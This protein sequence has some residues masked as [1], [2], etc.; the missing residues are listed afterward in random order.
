[1]LQ[2]FQISQGKT[3]EKDL[4]NRQAVYCA[5]R[6][7]RSNMWSSTSRDYRSDLSSYVLGCLK[8][9][10]QQVIQTTVLNFPQQNHKYFYFDGL[11]AK[12]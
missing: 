3:A 4:V 11:C 6:E 1:M 7:K 2:A 5:E 9:L 10:Q 8:F 12:L